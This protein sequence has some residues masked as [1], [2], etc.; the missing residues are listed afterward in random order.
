MADEETV[1]ETDAKRWRHPRKMLGAAFLMGTA[2]GAAAMAAK[3]R[4]EKSFWEKLVS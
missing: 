3:G 2:I 4:H 1:I